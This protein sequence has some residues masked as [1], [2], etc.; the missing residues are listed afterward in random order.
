MELSTPL[1][2][3]AEAMPALR[4][5]DGQ[6]V[7]T[8]TTTAS[9]RDVYFARNDLVR[10]W[11]DFNT[12]VSA[13]ILHEC[14]ASNWS[15]QEMASGAPATL[16]LK[17]E[18]LKC[19][20]EHTLQGRFANNALIPA[21]EAFCQLNVRR[22][23]KPKLQVPNVGDGR[24][25]PIPY[26]YDGRWPGCNRSIEADVAMTNWEDCAR[27]VGELKTCWTVEDLSDLLVKF[28]GGDVDNKFGHA[29]GMVTVF[30]V[31]SAL[32]VPTGQLFLYMEV[33]GSTHGF[34]STY[35]ETVVLKL[36]ENPSTRAPTIHVS[37]VI[38]DGASYKLKVEHFYALPGYAPPDNTIVTEP[39]KASITTK[40][41]MLY[42]ML[43]AS[44]IP[45]KGMLSRLPKDV[46]TYVSFEAKSAQRPSLGDKH[47]RSSQQGGPAYKG[48][49][50]EGG[51][52]EPSSSGST[53]TRAHGSNASKQTVHYRQ[54]ILVPESSAW[55]FKPPGMLSSKFR[56]LVPN[57]GW[58][59]FDAD[60]LKRDRKDQSCFY[61]TGWGG[62]GPGWIYLRA[63]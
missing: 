4:I 22:R 17:R 1:Q 43:T 46:Y 52:R 32:I 42:L 3:L 27:V 63:N 58:K 38:R 61:S 48:A 18:T 40:Q 12:D 51:A 23:K 28:T 7:S 35:Q 16:V 37:E 15:R 62:T 5:G 10:P 49:R 29:L 8:H 21:L 57:Q 39:H 53:Q 34:I 30:S 33:T 26:R 56:V 44:Q 2:F 60:R 31:A 45:A 54:E 25:V 14:E 47:A 13:L 50:T 20:N 24:I 36:E 11:N 55:T 41:A 19:G 6:P 9:M 59:E